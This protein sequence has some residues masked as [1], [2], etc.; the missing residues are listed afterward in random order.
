M[1]RIILL[2]FCFIVSASC[3]Q[4]ENN[5]LKIAVAA[6]MQFVMKEL[7]KSFTDDS[8]IKCD[9]IVGSSGQLTAQIRSGAPYDVFVS[10][11]MKY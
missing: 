4:K 6:N 2:F 3:N 8:G 10:A 5:T 9:L 1:G 7:C 11:D